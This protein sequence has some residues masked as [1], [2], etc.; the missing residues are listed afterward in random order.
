MGSKQGLSA[1]QGNLEASGTGKCNWKPVS[2]A[3]SQKDLWSFEKFNKGQ[4]FLLIVWFVQITASFSLMC[5]QYKE[6]F[7]VW[8]PMVREWVLYYIRQMS[9]LLDTKHSRVEEY[10]E[11][12]FI[13]CNKFKESIFYFVLHKE[14]QKCLLLI[15]TH[16]WLTTK[17]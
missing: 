2:E 4:S 13:A 8:E 16:S 10:R 7:L 17:R 12:P 9:N 15:S 3:F 5:S 14:N 6:S 11:W 1:Y